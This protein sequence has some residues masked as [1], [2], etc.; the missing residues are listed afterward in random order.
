MSG[1][2]GNGYN[3]GAHDTGGNINGGPTGIG[4]NGG[5][6]SGG[7]GSGSGWG[8]SNTPYGD[9]HHYDPDKF[10]GSRRGNSDSANGRVNINSNPGYR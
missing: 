9:I 2:D 1:G 8:I 5:S 3:S 10:G 7:S 6:S 4:G